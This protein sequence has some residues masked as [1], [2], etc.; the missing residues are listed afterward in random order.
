M[1]KRREVRKKVNIRA[2]IVSDVATY[3]A[4]IENI[5]DRGIHI[6]TNA[7][8]PLTK[9]KNIVPGRTMEVKFTLPSGE[10]LNLRGKIIWS[11]K[12]QPHGL[13]IS[14]GMEIV[15]PPP[16]YIDFCNS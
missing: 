6:E 4:T 7:G 5:S 13:T 2:E 14:I 16:S 12:T 9:E 15:F 3:Q 1:E 11:F 8:D 10:A